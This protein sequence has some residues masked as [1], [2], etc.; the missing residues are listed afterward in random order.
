MLHKICNKNTIKIS[1]SC[2]PSDGDIIKQHNARVR[3]E[4]SV[5]LHHTALSG[6]VATLPLERVYASF[7][8]SRARS[9]YNL[10][11]FFFTEYSTKKVNICNIIDLLNQSISCNIDLLSNVC[12]QMGFGQ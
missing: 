11:H 6:G 8:D 3:N 7:N 5:F 9:S 10:E 1:C 2:M 4:I 12:D